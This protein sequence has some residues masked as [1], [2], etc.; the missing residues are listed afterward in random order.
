MAE[1]V[2]GVVAAGGE[3]IYTSSVE[4]PG[5]YVS[6]NGGRTWTATDRGIIAGDL[7]DGLVAQRLPGGGVGR[8][9]VA[10]N[11]PLNEDPDFLYRSD[12]GL[13]WVKIPLQPVTIADA[14]GS[15]VLAGDVHGVSRSVDGGKTWSAV[16][17][18]PAGARG[19]R[20]SVTQPSYVALDSI[21]TTGPYDQITLWMSD[22][23][24]ATWRSSTL[25][26]QCTP[27]GGYKCPNY[28][29]YA[30]DPF[31]PSRRWAAYNYTEQGDLPTIFTSTD[32]GASWPELNF[33]L[34]LTR[35]L[36]ADPTV[37]G[38]LLTGT[39]GGLFVSADGGASW[40]P[41]GDLP[42][43]AVILQFAWDPLA[44][45]WYAA[46]RANGIFR[47]LDDGAHWT[48]LDGAPDLDA[49]TIAVD[50]RRPTALLAA[51]AG[52]GLWRWVP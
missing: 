4:T 38:R 30:V 12:G 49:P 9:V 20:P 6:P 28:P 32:G 24:G 16:P 8:R 11:T 3:R 13:D 45:S 51:F 42:D 5:L 41:L 36:A 15:V 40:Q 47:S 48:P 29:A 7:R 33:S 23:A 17:S 46:T 44:S 39:D 50:P 22:D 31:N 2:P 37:P 26:S 35:A 43:G 14:G 52:Q 10:L 34:P 18:A 27:L 25:S 21:D 19:F 1:P